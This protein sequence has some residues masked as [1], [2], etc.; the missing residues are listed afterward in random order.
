M[1]GTLNDQIAQGSRDPGEGNNSQRPKDAM[2]SQCMKDWLLDL[3][4]YCVSCTAAIC[5]TASCRLG[6]FLE[7]SA[8]IIW[9]L[10]LASGLMIFRSAQ[11]GIV[12]AV[13]AHMK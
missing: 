4:S 6:L 1:K 11:I 2:L 12:S 5:G 7:Q 9:N 3:H 8:D 13:M 10:L